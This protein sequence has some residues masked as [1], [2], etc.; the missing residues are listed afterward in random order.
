MLW[1][2]AFNGEKE[3]LLS[4]HLAR[5]EQNRVSDVDEKIKQHM[6]RVRTIHKHPFR[7]PVTNKAP[8]VQRDNTRF[9]A[10]SKSGAHSLL[11]PEAQ[12]RV[13]SA[14]IDSAAASCHCLDIWTE[15]GV[16]GW[17]VRAFCMLFTPH[18]SKRKRGKPTCAPAPTS[19]KDLVWIVAENSVQT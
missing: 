11:P 14:G 6:V 16:G 1:S 12:E 4:S 3:G 2:A 7:L 19:D 18:C 10:R 9:A 17:W 5:K 8:C 15:E 13:Q